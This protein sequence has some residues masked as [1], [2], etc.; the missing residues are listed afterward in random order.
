M[1]AAEVFSSQKWIYSKLGSDIHVPDVEELSKVVAGL[2]RSAMEDDDE[3]EWPLQHS[4][5]R[6]MVQ[7][8]EDGCDVYF[9]LGEVPRLVPAGGVG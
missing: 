8:N 4:T 9:H 5:G 6:F 7:A 1:V 2:I 3:A